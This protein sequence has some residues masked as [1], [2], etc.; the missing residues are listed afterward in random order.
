MNNIKVERV[1][2]GLTQRGLA[3]RLEVDEQTV[4]RWEKEATPVP[5]TKAVEMSDLFGCSTDYLFGL[6]EERK[7]ASIS[8]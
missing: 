5:S 6:T 3:K 7:P 1:R 4:G 2:I 8:Q